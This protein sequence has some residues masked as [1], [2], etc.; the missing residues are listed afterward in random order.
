MNCTKMKEYRIF[1]T[2]CIET[3]EFR[4]LSQWNSEIKPD[5]KQNIHTHTP[6]GHRNIRMESESERKMN[7]SFCIEDPFLNSWLF[8]IQSFK[9][10]PPHCRHTLLLACNTRIWKHTGIMERE[11]EKT[12]GHQSQFSKFKATIYI[13]HLRIP[14]RNWEER[15]KNGIQMKNKNINHG[16]VKQSK[17]FW[18]TTTKNLL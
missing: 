17:Y 7:E 18:E 6:N 8:E 11:R 5:T 3:E 16:T 13:K 15:H 14:N 9:D 1:W 2:L 12:N 4:H 10:F